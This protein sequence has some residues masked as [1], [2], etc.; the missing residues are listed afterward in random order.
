MANVEVFVRFIRKAQQK[1]RLFDWL[2][3]EAEI[4]AYVETCLKE[5]ETG[6]ADEIEEPESDEDQK[7][8]ALHV[9]KMAFRYDDQCLE[10]DAAYEHLIESFS[11][12]AGEDFRPKQ[13]E[14]V[15]DDE[16]EEWTITMSVNGRKHEFSLD[17][18]GDYVPNIEL[19][20]E[21]N[22]VLKSQSAP[23]R[24]YLVGSGE[25]TVMYLRP[26]QME[27]NRQT[28]FVPAFTE[29]ETADEE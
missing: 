16:D 10:S 11:L 20:E 5:D 27:L 1:V 18:Y 12:L 23:G 6:W 29:A 15:F 3:S 26:I 28:K 17:Y 9:L 14:A 24:F 13:I 4:R 8:M 25:P 2:D 21:M 7:I 19:V 22:G